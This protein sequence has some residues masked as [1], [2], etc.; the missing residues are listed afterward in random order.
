MNTRPSKATRPSRHLRPRR[1][2]AALLAGALT[3]G[4]LSMAASAREDAVIIPG[5]A[6]SIPE[7]AGTQSVVL[8]GGCFWGVQAVYQHVNGVENALSGYTGGKTRAPSYKQVTSGRTGHAEAVKIIYDPRQVSFGKILQIYFSVVHDPTQLNRQGPDRGTQ[9]RS[10]IF[11]TSDA[12]RKLAEGYIAQLDKAG[13]WKKPIVTR[14]STL[15]R[16]HPAEDYH[17]DYA[18]RHPD[19]P[20]IAFNDLPKVDNL[21]RVFPA[22]YRSDPVTV[23]EAR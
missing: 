2:A 6:M 1:L 18:L 15:E 10:E 17:Q 22:V 3:A 23:A 12:Q 8:A 19:Q 7:E 4:G 20:Y 21:K 5:P 14:V 16:F 13:A 11:V 9:Y